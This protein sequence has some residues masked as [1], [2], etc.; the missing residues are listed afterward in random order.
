LKTWLLDTGPF[1]AYLDRSD[2]AHVR[3][4]A[5]W[6]SFRGQLATTSAVITESMHLITETVEGP[7]LMAELVVAS[8]VVIHDYTQ[9]PSLRA[10][11][12]LMKKYADTPMDFADATLVL[13]ADDLGVRDILTLDRRGFTVFR[14]RTRRSFQLLP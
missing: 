8:G 11:A 12:E 13:L 9:P 4:A 7:G 1:V 2:P 14:T 6:D 5:V 3:T 10:A